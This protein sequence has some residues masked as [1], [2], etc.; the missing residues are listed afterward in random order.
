MYFEVV[1]IV[2]AILAIAVFIGGSSMLFFFWR[3]FDEG[4]DIHPIYFNPSDPLAKGP[5]IRPVEPSKASG[6][7]GKAAA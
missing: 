7:A 1:F 3:A 4:G 6:L 5:G 2:M